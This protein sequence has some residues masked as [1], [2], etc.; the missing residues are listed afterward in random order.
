M[1]LRTI[2][3]IINIVV[4]Q[5]RSVNFILNKQI[6][7]YTRKTIRWL[8]LIAVALLIVMT[9]VFLKYDL[10]CSVSL[11]G[12]QV[13]YIQNKE[14]FERKVAEISNQEGTG[15][16]AFVDITEVPE[17]EFTLV[18]KDQ[19]LNEEDILSKIEESTEVTYKYYAV[20]LDGEQKSIVNSLEEAEKLV[21]EM[22]E[23]YEDSVDFTIGIN[24]LYTKDKDEYET[25][26]IEVAEAKVSEQLQEIAD[27]S[28]NGVY[29]SQRPVSGV[30][31][32]RFGNRESIRT[33]AH[34]G[35]DIAAPYGTPIKAAAGGTV[36]VAQYSGS[37]GNLIVVDCGNGVEIY[38]GHC[39]SLYVSAGDEVEA[40]DVIG[41]VGSTGNSTGNH[42]HFEIRVNGTRVNPQNYIYN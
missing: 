31:T 19:E 27:A 2:Y 8:C 15:N 29:L 35:L 1:K 37:Y 33:Y 14:S 11:A 28:V 22:E 10:V 32:S 26:D 3:G 18:S 5:K 38:Y 25:V 16:I 9:A 34:T 6:K 20:T 42:L 39:S 7:Y 41:A 36:S 24:E 30:I 4:Q 17:Y 21:A 23:E 13:G 40:G 12:E